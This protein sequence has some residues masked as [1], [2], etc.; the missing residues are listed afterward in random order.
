LSASRY[1]SQA[2]R[3][4]A[5]KGLLLLRSLQAAREVLGTELGGIAVVTSKSPG[6]GGADPVDNRVIENT[7]LRNQPVDLFYDGTGG[8][9]LFQDNRCKTSTLATLCQ[10]GHGD[11]GSSGN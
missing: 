6:Q 9:N 1:N 3:C 5:C 7:A 8:D 11:H 10:S 4:Q 2:T